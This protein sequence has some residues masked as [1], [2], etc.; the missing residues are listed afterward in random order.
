MTELDAILPVAAPILVCLAGFL[1]SLVG[2]IT[3]PPSDQ[4]RSLF[5]VG[6][7]A[8]FLLLSGVHL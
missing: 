2:I 4:I 6:T 3:S 5:F 7:A 1:V 8:L